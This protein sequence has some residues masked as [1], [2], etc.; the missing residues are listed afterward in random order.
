MLEPARHLLIGL[1]V[2]LA[3]AAP[4]SQPAPLDPSFRLSGA[5]GKTFA[6][7]QAARDH[8]ARGVVFIFV[9][10]DCPISNGY[11]PEIRRICQAYEQSQDQPARFDFYLV[12]ADPDLT[13][14]DAKKHAADFGYTCPVLMDPK[15]ELVSRLGA[16]VTPEAFVVSPAGE[17]LYRGR[18]DDQ[19]VAYGKRR[20]QPTRH[21]LRQALDE[22]LAGKPVSAPLT[23]AVGCPI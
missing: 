6:P 19:Y 11:S 8:A 23:P 12:H 5:D 16:K 9:A 10:I 4:A 15:K 1:F 13:P 18:I 3:G 7:I 2:M 14:D 20:E 21:D 17:L 22:I